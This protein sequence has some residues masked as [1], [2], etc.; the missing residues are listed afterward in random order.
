MNLYKNIMRKEENM[1]NVAIL[2]G[3]TE[4]KEKSINLPMC[5]KDVESMYKII[6]ASGKYE[7]IE[8]LKGNIDS[9]KIRNKIMEL[10]NKIEEEIGELFFYFSGHGY[11]ANNNFYFCTSD[12]DINDIN[13]TSILY[14]QID[15]IVR[16][17]NPRLYVKVVDAC[18]SS[19]YYIK[20]FNCTPKKINNCYFMF[21]SKQ[22][23][24]SFANKYMSDFTRFFIEAII[25]NKEKE[26]IKYV[27]IS[28]YLADQFKKQKQTPE[29]ITQ[30]DMLN[31]FISYNENV[32]EIL[33]VLENEFH[34]ENDNSSNLNVQ[35]SL[36]ERINEK[37]KKI[38]TKEMYY[39]FMKFFKEKLSSIQINNED[40][41]KEFNLRLHCDKNIEKI[42]DK[43]IIANWVYENKEKYNLFASSN[44]GELRRMLAYNLGRTLEKINGKNEIEN[45]ERVI[46]T[47]NSYPFHYE[48]EY[49]PKSIGLP[50][51]AIDIIIISSPYKMYIFLQN[52]VY[53]LISWNDYELK[54]TSK[55]QKNEIEIEEKDEIA[56]V[57]DNYK[58]EFESYVINSIN[59]YLNKLNI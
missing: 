10:E 28:N 52:K 57:I 54:D 1:K 41:K 47:E 2:I 46:V 49:I 25:K 9:E 55:W 7:Y 5:E 13:S 53:T 24:T 15:D 12:T 58:K 56:K 35:V 45:T 38:A 17:I 40:L 19:T 32:N 21:S 39:E 51:Y 8:V 36:H 4:Y 3:I 18:Y 43:A 26:S 31:E 27:D 34:T 50:K 16:R 48:I 37:I 44:V 23:Q 11:T 22:T 6:S 33:N 42:S 59:E 20:D 30:G 29:F 14:N